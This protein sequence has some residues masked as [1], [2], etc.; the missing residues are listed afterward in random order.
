[1]LLSAVREMDAALRPALRGPFDGAQARKLLE[2]MHRT[3]DAHGWTHEQLQALAEGY[4]TEPDLAPV[5]AS[6]W[7]SWASLL[8]SSPNDV[9]EDAVEPP[10]LADAWL[11]CQEDVE[12]LEYRHIEK[13]AVSRIVE[14]DLY[15][16][17]FAK[18]EPVQQAITPYD[19]GRLGVIC[20]PDY[21]VPGLRKLFQDL[22]YPSDNI[23][24]V[25][26]A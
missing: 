7:S 9:D 19:E 10:E 8:P 11:Q 17:A 25:P 26:I 23:I 4:S 20:A 3:C 6:A 1:M 12:A 2:L 15:A 18:S 14:E 5:F 16:S 13:L 21:I 24:T 22:G